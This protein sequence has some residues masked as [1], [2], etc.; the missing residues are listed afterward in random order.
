MSHITTGPYL[1]YQTAKPPTTLDAASNRS[2][3]AG[4]A[5]KYSHV[6]SVLHTQRSLPN[7]SPPSTHGQSDR[8]TAFNARV[9]VVVKQSGGSILACSRPASPPM[10]SPAEAPEAPDADSS[11]EPEECPAAGQQDNEATGIALTQ[12]QVLQLSQCSE[13]GVV[14]TLVAQHQ[15]ISALGTSL[16]R[17]PKLAMLDLSFNIMRSNPLHGLHACQSLVCIV[18]S[19]NE[20]TNVPAGLECCSSLQSLDL[21]HNQI[22]SLDRLNRLPRLIT[23]NLSSNWIHSVA[24]GTFPSSLTQLDL[25]A[26][27]L[28]SIPVCTVNCRLASAFACALHAHTPSMLWHVPEQCLKESLALR[29]LVLSENCLTRCTDLSH[30]QNLEELHLTDN[31]LSTLA[32]IGC[33]PKLNE[34]HCSHNLL[35]TL[36]ASTLPRCPVLSELYV[37]S[38]A[39]T[40]VSSS[41][42]TCCPMLDTVDLADNHISPESLSSVLKA[43]KCK[44]MCLTCILATNR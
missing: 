6:R 12:A 26:N 40:S 28:E 10:R 29:E 17:C 15:N 9:S 37:S 19:H 25:S 22:S 43:C 24:N 23:L 2:V 4:S 39:V 7:E 11:I 18:L 27:R 33:L 21:S 8:E 14:H 34:L 20:L 44:H 3:L 16:L 42:A 35:E 32:S 30:L 1:S 41:L 13:L 36:S 5:K 38:N 31:G